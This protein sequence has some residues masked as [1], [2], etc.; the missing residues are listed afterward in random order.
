MEFVTIEVQRREKKGTAH[1]RRLRSG[2]RVPAVLYGLGK[3]NAD[4]SIADEELERFLKTGSRLVE[5]KLGGE[6]RQAILREIQHDPLSDAIVH[7][8]LQRIDKDHE[9]ETKVPFE[10]KGIAKGVSEGGVFEA[11]LQE[12][13]VRA[14][15]ARLPRVILIDVSGLKLN[16]ALLVKDL[17]LPEGVKVLQHKPEDHVCHCVPVKIVEVAPV[18]AAAEGAAPAEPERIGGK[19]PEEEAPAEEGKAAAKGSAPAAKPAKEEKKK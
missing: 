1:S 17:P 8:D 10:F 18:V 9:I 4:L 12:V 13:L 14:T 5:L 16:D 2:G 11:V 7:V 3:A 6:T 19:K 15:P